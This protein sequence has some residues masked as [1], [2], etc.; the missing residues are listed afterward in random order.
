[1]QGEVERGIFF[2][3]AGPAGVG[4]S[5]L[6]RRLVAEEKDLRKAVSVTTRSARPGEIEGTS[7]FFW[8][9][10]RFTAAA[11]HGDIL[12]HA[13]VYGHHYGT[14]ARFVEEQLAAGVD[15]IKDID[16][17]GVGQVRQ[18]PAFRY[19]RSVAV[20]IL[21]PSRAELIRRLKER[22]SETSVS[23]ELRLKTA[24]AELARLAEY[25]YVIVN[26]TIEESVHKL[27]AIRVAEHCRRERRET[28]R[29]G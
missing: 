15:V 26:D 22:A 3:V 28:G 12:E 2:L 5:T 27:K 4:K 20:F 29:A 8:D 10:K 6:L 19:P 9:E 18:N 23:F 13:A 16:V 24:D 7:Y 17:Q 21:P 25:D 1:V 11:A 14:L